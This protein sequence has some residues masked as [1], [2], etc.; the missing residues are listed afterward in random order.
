M[1]S[2][3]ASTTAPPTP[4]LNMPFES[5]LLS[6]LLLSSPPRRVMA[7]GDGAMMIELEDRVVVVRKGDSDL[8]EV[9]RP[10]EKGERLLWP[11]GMKK[12]VLLGPKGVL[13]VYEA[14]NVIESRAGLLLEDDELVDALDV[15]N[16]T[17]T[18]LVGRMVGDQFLL[19]LPEYRFVCVN[20]KLER[21]GRQN[22]VLKRRPVAWGIYGMGKEVLL[23]AKSPEADKLKAI[24]FETGDSRELKRP[25][26]LEGKRIT[27]M[28]VDPTTGN[29]VLTVEWDKGSELGIFSPRE[30]KY[31]LLSP[32]MVG[33]PLDRP[34]LSPDSKQVIYRKELRG[35]KLLVAIAVGSGSAREICALGEGD[36]VVWLDNETVAV[37]Q[38]DKVQRLLLRK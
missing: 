4:N 22:E 33:E 10:E 20:S 37:V 29:A 7:A 1:Y 38:W 2:P 26:N 6:T 30:L 5:L 12:C 15:G 36:E 24:A 28:S 19:P 9:C 27:G 16:G 8:E 32:S 25:I 35:K 13:K 17:F 3:L 14:Q 11:M 23:V 31:S 18:L 34:C 21:F